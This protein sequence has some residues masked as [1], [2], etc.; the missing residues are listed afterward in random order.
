M[1]QAKRDKAYA[2]MLEALE[3]VMGT[4]QRDSDEEIQQQEIDEI[5]DMIMRA[6]T[7]ARESNMTDKPE[8]PPAFPQHYIAREQHSDRPELFGMALRDYFAAAA[9]QGLNANPNRKG[10]SEQFAAI[11]YSMADAMLKAR[12]E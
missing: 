7:E 11:S 9:L 12:G 5:G 8:N 1:T 4:L 3:R 6:I 2:G 10:K